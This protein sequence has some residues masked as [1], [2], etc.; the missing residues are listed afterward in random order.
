MPEIAK[1][2]ENGMLV[3]VETCH[4]DDH[5]TCPI[6]R[7][8]ALPENHDMHQR[9]KNYRWDFTRQC[10]MPLSAEPLDVGERD[11][12]ELVEGLVEAI[13]YL[14]EAFNLAL[15]KRTKRVLGN[16]RRVNPRRTLGLPAPR[17][18][19]TEPEGP[20]DQA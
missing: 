20:E 13:E 2:D 6:A 11:T 4:G 8:V 9:A 14:E 7:T 18:R 5:K 12:P 1:L 16:Y 10:F 19:N 17:S 3:S 15:P